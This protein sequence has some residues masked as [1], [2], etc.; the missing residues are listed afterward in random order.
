MERWTFTTESSEETMAFAKKLGELLIAGDVVTLEGDLGAGK[1]SFAKGLAKGLGIKRNVNS[2]TFTI[3]K[4]YQGRLPLYHMDV[5]RME[6]GQEELGL[7]EYFYGDGVSVIEWA[8][9]IKDQLPE[10]RLDIELHHLGENKR[11]VLVSPK[12]TRYQQLCEEL[13]K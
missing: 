11:E 8:S 5:Y 1:T 12:G 2:P 13:E 7:E 6:N 3:I 9:V 10:A 4:E